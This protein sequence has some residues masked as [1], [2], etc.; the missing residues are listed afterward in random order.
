VLQQNSL[1]LTNAKSESMALNK[2]NGWQRIWVVATGILFIYFSG[3]KPMEAE[4]DQLTVHIRLYEDAYGDFR[5]PQC[6]RYQ[7]EAFA[8]LP[9]LSQD[10]ILKPGSCSHIWRTRKESSNPDAPYTERD[11]DAEM[12]S[13]LDKAYKQTLGYGTAIA[14]VLSALLYAVGFVVAWVL[15]G[16]RIPR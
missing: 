12:Q 13:R 9:P 6:R 15:R 7:T 5:T 14:F 3:Y 16:F 11:F 2:L 8:S 4:S 1:D 10:D